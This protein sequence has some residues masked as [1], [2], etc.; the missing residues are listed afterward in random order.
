MKKLSTVFLA[1]IAALQLYGYNYFIASG[2]YR[3][4]ISEKYCHTIREIVWKNFKIGTPSGFY[5]AIFLPARGKY[6]GAGHT[7]GGAE[8]VLSFKVIC[9]GKKIHPRPQMTIK[10]KKITVDK[11]SRF[12]NLIFSVRLEL[13]PAGLVETKRFTAVAD[14]T[15]HSYY[16]HIFCFNKSFTDYY[17]LTASGEIL[18]GKFTLPKLKKLP[19]EPEKRKLVK[20]AWHIN[21]SVKYISEYDAAAKKGVLLYYPEII[22]GKGRKS[23]IWEVP[24]AYMK[25][26]MITDIPDF[27]PANWESPVY[28][29]ILRGFETNSVENIP[30]IIQKEVDSAAKIK[31]SPVAKPE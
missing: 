27:V 4:M 1:A 20:K 16:A 14:Q 28:T 18:K 19:K 15:V 22:P 30:Q 13:S 17:A 26:Y 10:G 12:D 5:G 24:Y 7:Q 29:V 31:F 9:D 3:I 21:T 6:I 23:A 8:K 25:Y 2:D 11:I